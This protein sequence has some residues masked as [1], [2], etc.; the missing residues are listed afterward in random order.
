MVRC[1]TKRQRIKVHEAPR[2]PYHCPEYIPSQ[3][4]RLQGLPAEILLCV[5][6]CFDSLLDIR[7][8][9]CLRTVVQGTNL[10]HLGDVIDDH[11]NQQRSDFMNEKRLTP[12]WNNFINKN[13]YETDDTL[14]QFVGKQ[15]VC[16]AEDING[17]PWVSI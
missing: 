10:S 2:H 12:G 3:A 17:D 11:L 1:G 4:K 13:R 14:R 15:L 7:A 5:V 9:R 8:L 6:A 16:E